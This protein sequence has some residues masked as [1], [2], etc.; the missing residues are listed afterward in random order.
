MNVGTKSLL[1]GVH[2]FLWHPLTVGLAWRKCHRRWPKWREW[3]AIFCHDI[4][5]FGSPNMDGI[6]GRRHPER[7]AEIATRIVYFIQRRILFSDAETAMIRGL[8]TY[9]LSLY[10]STHYAR[11]NDAEVS[12][13]YLPDK[14]SILFEPKWF[15]LLRARLSG[16]IKEYVAN[17]PAEVT[18]GNDTVWFL[19]FRARVS[20]KL[21]DF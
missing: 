5:Y 17:A 1:F 16:E 3:V 6:E 20:A 10:H 11:M 21:D 18:L 9:W 4:G 12:A 15:Y 14:V 19:W 13:L 8:E 2:Q 7:G